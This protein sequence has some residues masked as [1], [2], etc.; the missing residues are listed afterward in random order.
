MTG[1]S[2]AGVALGLT[3][4]ITA[5][6]LVLSH[7]LPA[8]GV[9]MLYILAIVTSSVALG[10]WTGLSAATL[11][12][13]AYNF[14][15]IAPAYT[16]AI[17]DPRDM[18]ALFV[19]YGVAAATGSLAGRMREVAERARQRA[20]S[21]KALNDFAAGLSGALTIGAA[22]QALA[23]E[24]AKLF[25]SP[26]VVL[27][28]EDLETRASVP[29][30]IT[31]D[32]ADVQA[33]QRAARNKDAVYPSA[34]GWPGSSFEFHPVLAGDRRVAL[35]GLQRHETLSLEEDEA[36]QSML[37]NAAI[38]FDRIALE[39]EKAA[40]RQDA[41]RERLRS[42]LLSS[43]SHDLK[44]PLASI[45]GAATS[46]RELG[47][48]MPDET[49]ADLL[50]TIEEEAVRLSRF[51]TNL[52]DMTRMD[53]GE[54]DITRDWIDLQ[55][56]IA[57]SVARARRLLPTAEFVIDVAAPNALVRGDAILFEH[58]VL[59][60]LDNA[61]RFSAERLPIVV[62]LRQTSDDYTVTID[63]QGSGIRPQD[64]PHVFD[65]FYRGSHSPSVPG[66]GLG[67][68]IGRRVV[69]AMGGVI[70]A[71][72]PL[73]NGRGT[74]ISMCFPKPRDVPQS[75]HVEGGAT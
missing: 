74:R 11:S 4:I 32:S 65:K 3:A 42:A 47:S 66:T 44:T 5:A 63:D 49:R 25:S 1:F 34:R 48:R 73:E 53:S 35:L 58:V 51:V 28:G 17:N 69:A 33:A 72:S 56:I 19:F 29:D 39:G 26:A 31:L 67:L 52:L 40:A 38:A 21:L 14:F 8:H 20:A 24:A 12:F 13:L 23:S 16:F 18:F 60:V 6:G 62:R 50:L 15:F 54:P 64:L 10:T 22:S 46:L 71:E 27:G 43:I 30:H 7:W 9:A 36:L 45:Q 61:A 37:Q 41:E 75:A 57:A 70:S 2:A 55:D 68:A 59:N